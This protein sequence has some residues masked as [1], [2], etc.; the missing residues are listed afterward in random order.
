MDLKQK[1]FD[2]IKRIFTCDTLLVYPNFNDRFDIHT[3]ASNCHIVSV[4]V[5][6]DKKNAFYS[7]KIIGP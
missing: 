7:R 6:A 4:V 5:Q 1:S 3:D 2:E